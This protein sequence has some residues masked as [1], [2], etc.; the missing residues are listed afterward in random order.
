MKRCLPIVLGTIV[1]LAPI[2]AW[3]DNGKPAPA[4][5]T[6]PF[7]VFDNMPKEAGKGDTSAKGLVECVILPIPWKVK[8]EEADEAAF[9]AGVAK[10]LADHPKIGLFVLDIEY[11]YLSGKDAAEVKKHF[12][13]FIHLAK[14][15]HE[16]APGHKVGYY[17]HG[18]FPE[19]PGKEYATETKELIAAVDAF[20]PSMYNFNDNR[21]A[22]KN[23]LKGY[24]EQAHRIA[25]GKPVCPYMWP[26]YHM[27]TK[28]A[29][30]LLSG[31]YWKFQLETARECGADGL[32]IWGNPKAHWSDK[33]TWWEETLNFMASKPMVAKPG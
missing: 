29:L 27:S 15:V 3:A 19:Q 24:V 7:V 13:L 5:G 14:W 11:V 17:G 20:L 28:N 25:P 18:L 22:W 6:K 30:H 2:Q 4:S 9:K 31:D 10:A 26:G 8:N 32:I 23:K 1:L 33:S 16:A 12:Q 21:E